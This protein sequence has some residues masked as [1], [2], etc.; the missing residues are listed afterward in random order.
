MKKIMLGIGLLALLI[1][2]SAYFYFVSQRTVQMIPF[3]KIDNTYVQ[4]AAENMEAF[5]KVKV[6]LLDQQS[7]P[8]AAFYAPRK[9]YRADMMLDHLYH[10]FYSVRDF[11][12]GLTESDISTTKGDVYDYGIIGLANRPGLVSIVSTYRCGKGV[13]EATKRDRF[14][15]SVLHEFG[16]NLGLEHCS[17]SEHCLM[18][19]AKGK[20]STIDKEKVELCEQCKRKVSA[21]LQK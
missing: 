12:M 17:F 10:N 9:R 7:F 15:K 2:A 4:L 6:E 11:R 21:W 18:N 16:H 3:G 5:Y 19:D 14:V 13:D 1:M 20:A 8:E